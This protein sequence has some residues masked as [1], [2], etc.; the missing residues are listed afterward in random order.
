MSID[1]SVCAPWIMLNEQHIM[2]CTSTKNYTGM[3][4]SSLARC[5]QMESH[6]KKKK[7]KRRRRLYRYDIWV[8]LELSYDISPTQLPNTM[9]GK[10]HVIQ[11]Y[12]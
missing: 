12:E 4:D 11:A 6:S 1:I 9:E 3:Q 7:K 10:L 5:P 2:T 8:L